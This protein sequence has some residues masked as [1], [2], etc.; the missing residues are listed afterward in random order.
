M[1]WV[2]HCLDASNIEEK[3]ASVL[4]DHIAY[5]ATSPLTTILAGPLSAEDG[6]STGSL[7]IVDADKRSDVEKF[8]NNAPFALN[9]VWG[10]T[11]IDMFKP[12]V[13]A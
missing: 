8:L 6:S 10:E 1:H 2:I 5:V 12:L 3:R 7:I 9:G 13:S 11:R 4:S